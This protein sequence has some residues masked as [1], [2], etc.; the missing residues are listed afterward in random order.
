MTAIDFMYNI[1]KNDSNDNTSIQI[2]VQASRDDLAVS[3]GVFALFGHIAGVADHDNKV[4]TSY[5]DAITTIFSVSGQDFI[6][7]VDIVL[8]TTG[9]TV[10][11]ITPYV[12]NGAKDYVAGQVAAGDTRTTSTQTLSLVGTGATGTQISA[13]KASTVRFSV[14]TSTTSTIGGAST[15][16]VSL[17]KCATN[18][19][20]EGNWT[21]VAVLENDQTI[22]LALVLQSLQVMKG[23]LATDLDAGWY[24]KLVNS[25]SGTHSEAFI[26][27]EKTIY[28]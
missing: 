16:L 26:S 5:A 1:F 14:S 19:A 18:S 22:T 4:Y 12:L 6:D 15:S 20:T 11:T 24:V 17:K 25:G 9:S 3:P 7:A 10:G 23:Q 13:T 28:G 27:G 2:N 21:T 8:G